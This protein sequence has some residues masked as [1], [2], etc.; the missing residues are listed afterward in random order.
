MQATKMGWRFEEL[1]RGSLIC[2]YHTYYANIS[3]FI[4]KDLQLYAYTYDWSGI[5]SWFWNQ[6]CPSITICLRSSIESYKY[7]S[8][9]WILVL[10]VQGQSS[11]FNHGR[12]NYK[13]TNPQ[14]SSLLLFLFVYTSKDDI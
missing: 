8:T 14:M 7:K 3:H 1:F 11:A 2:F 10:P 13:D 5:L 6:K 12:R 4:L 9:R